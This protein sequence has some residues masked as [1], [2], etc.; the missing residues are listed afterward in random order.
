MKVIV[1]IL[2]ILALVVFQY[3][4]TTNGVKLNELYFI[5]NSIAISFFTL[6]SIRKNDNVFVSS[7]LVLCAAFFLS[8]V[9][10]YIKRWLFLGDGSTN[11]YIAISISTIVTFLYLI[12]YVIN[13]FIKRKHS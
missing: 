5:S 11:Y 8:T 7:V 1:A 2:I 9:L 12:T 6:T 13:R 3:E 4:F 10:I